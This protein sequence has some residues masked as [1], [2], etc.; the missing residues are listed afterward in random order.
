MDVSSGSTAPAAARP[1]MTSH[2]HQPGRIS[3]EIQHR[4]R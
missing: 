3:H 2:L 1:S 4:A